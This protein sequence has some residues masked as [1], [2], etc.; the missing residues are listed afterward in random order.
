MGRQLTVVY[1]A[2]VLYSGHLRDVLMQLAVTALFQ[3]NQ[4]ERIH[5][6]WIRNL[7]GNRPDINLNKLQRLR[8]CL[9]SPP[10]VI[11]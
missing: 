8:G 9:K 6:E 7:L 1:D 11:C 4:T 5:N 2:C 3:V 10:I